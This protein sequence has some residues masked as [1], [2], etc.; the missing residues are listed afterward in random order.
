[1]A[2]SVAC[3]RTKMVGVDDGMLYFFFSLIFGLLI[4]GLLILGFAD[5][6]FC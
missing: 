3:E 1:M 6:G 5:F 4:F 2:C